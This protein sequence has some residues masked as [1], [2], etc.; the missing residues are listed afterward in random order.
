[1]AEVRTFRTFGLDTDDGGC[2]RIG[3][4]VWVVDLVK[5][6]NQD[7]VMPCDFYGGLI[8]RV[9][10]WGAEVV[11]D[12][13]LGSK[14]INLEREPKDLVFK[15]KEKAEEFLAKFWAA[16]EKRQVER[17]ADITEKILFRKGCRKALEARQRQQKTEEQLWKELEDA[18]QRLLKMAES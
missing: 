12:R 8:E 13:R 5:Y 2:V 10:S 4:M 11:V 9:E 17:L 6:D 18:Q 1:M 3:D 14:T 15:S 7:D 16:L